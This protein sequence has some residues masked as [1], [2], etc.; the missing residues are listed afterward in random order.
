[1]KLFYLGMICVLTLVSCKQAV[2]KTTALTVDPPVETSTYYLIRHAE[3]D[4]S[5]TKNPDPELNETGIVR[6]KQWANYFD[7]IHLDAIY[8]TKYKRT[9]RTAAPTAKNKELEVQIYDASKLFSE[10]FKAN[11]Q[12]KSVLVVG[13]SNTTPHFA[14]AILGEKRFE[15]MNDDDNSSLFVVTVRDDEKSVT[16]RNVER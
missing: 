3:K 1:M 6:A 13:H 14:N 8:S 9:Q 2:E 16:V 12:G 10:S 7:T 15:N 4:R 11:T 5:D